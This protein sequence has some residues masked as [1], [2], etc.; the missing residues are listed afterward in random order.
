MTPLKAVLFDY[1]DTLI[2]YSR[3][4]AAPYLLTAYEAINRRL[5]EEL[6]REV[7][8]A[9]L[10]VEQVSAGV[11]DVLAR[12][13]QTGSL[14]EVDIAAVYA[15]RFAELGLSLPAEVLD[16]VMQAE[17]EAWWQAVGPG[18]FSRPTLQA[19]HAAGLRLGIVS[20]AAFLPRLMDQSVV[21]KGLAPFL[22]ST[23]W[24]SEVGRRK[25]DPAIFHAALARVDSR[26]EE[27]LFVGDR[28]GEDILGAR[29]V[30]M[31]AVLTHEFRQE[32]D[33]GRAAER[34]I[35]RLDQLIEHV[36]CERLKRAL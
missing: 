17:Q 36:G 34:V 11:D 28:L 29:A 21:R 20:N 1:G 27:A 22:T 24:S 19:L 5:K 32:P 9:A 2:T 6:A 3:S 16:W 25:P 4:A 23:T 15:A 30:G 14:Q 10:L 33:P 13:Y 26:P 12:H 8:P 35:E 31:R 18:P 7:P